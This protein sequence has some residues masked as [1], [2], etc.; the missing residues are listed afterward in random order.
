MSQSIGAYSYR[1]VFLHWVLHC[2][3]SCGSPI[4]ELG[5]M[6]S[7]SCSPVLLEEV[8]LDGEVGLV[9]RITVCEEDACLTSVQCRSRTR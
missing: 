1:W 3:R 5:K 8:V 7:S 9:G 2:E 4:G 6:F